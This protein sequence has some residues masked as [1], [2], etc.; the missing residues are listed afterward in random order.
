LDSFAVLAL[1]H[2]EPGYIRVRELLHEAARGTAELHM[3]L[4]NLVEVRYRIIRQGRD[5]QSRLS[6]VESLPVHR[7]SADAYI[8]AVVHLKAAHPVALA[9]CFAVALAQELDC[10]VLTGDPEFKKLEGEVT[11]EWLG[12]NP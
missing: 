8:D 1:I 9:D 12:P 3:S 5:V 7:G 6:A 4:I 10:P 2:G 11:V